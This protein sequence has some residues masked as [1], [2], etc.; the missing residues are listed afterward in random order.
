L[1]KSRLKSNVYKKD[2]SSFLYYKFSS[3]NDER[4]LKRGQL[5]KDKD[6]F[7]EKE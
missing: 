1:N 3:K 6:S 5:N 7:I 4:I 2:K